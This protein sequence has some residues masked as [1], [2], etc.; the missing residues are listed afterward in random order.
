MKESCTKIKNML[1]GISFLAMGWGMASCGGGSDDP[2]PGGGTPDNPGG[3]GTGGGS[4]TVPTEALMPDRTNAMKVYAHMMP[5]F[6]TD[7]T[8][9]DKGKWGWHWT[10]NA[11]LNPALGEIASHYHPLTGAYASGDATILD[12]QCLL[13]KYAGLEGVMVDWYGSDA[14]NTTARHTSNTEAIFKAIQKAGMKMAIVYEDNTVGSAADAVGKARDDMRYLASHFFG[15]DHYAKVDGKPLLL[16]FGPQALNTPKDWY[17]TFQILE[18][19]PALV[20]LNGHID[21]AN[22]DGFENAIGEYLWVNATPDSWYATAKSRFQ[23]V[24][25]GAMPGF[26]DYYKQGGAGDGYTTYDDEGGALFDRQLNA[27][28]NAGLQWLQISTWNDYGEGTIIEPTQEFGYRYLTKL[29]SFTGVKYKESDLQTIFRW[30]QMKVKY[31]SDAAKTQVLD[32]C[33]AYLNALQP[34]KAAE[35]MNQQQMTK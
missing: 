4:G 30:Y 21:K 17:R 29:Q 16:V 11:S 23:M 24:M 14:D 32:Q 31:A 6:E 12:Y 9:L 28:K 10:M 13:M 3:G 7:K 22:G 25:G 34:D 27:A 20:V 19:P 33:Y 15:S 8:S 26:K 2:T 5:W 1:M 35:L 18:T